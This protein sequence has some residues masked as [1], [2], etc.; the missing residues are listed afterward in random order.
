MNKKIAKK[1]ILQNF[2]PKNTKKNS[3]KVSLGS[4]SY[5]WEEVYEALDSMLKMRTTM[6]EKVG[7]FEKMFAKYIGVKYALMVNSG[8]SANLLAL[9]I[10]SNPLLKNRRIK[11]NDEI[12]TPA[13]TWST[14]VFPIVNIH[15][16]PV[17]L[18]VDPN[19]YNIDTKMIEK[20]ITKKTKAILP[21]HLLGNPCKMNEIKKIAKKYDLY[22]IEDCCEALG[23]KIKNKKVGSFGDLSTFSFFISHHITTM[24]GGM[25]L[26]NNEKF[27][28]LGKSLRTHGWSRDLKDKK[29]LIQ[30]NPNINSEFLFSNLGYNLRPT[31]IQGGFGIHQL[32]KLERFLK[33]RKLNADIW[34]KNLEK[35]EEFIELTKTETGHTHANMLF[36]IRIK[37]NKYFT[38]N[39]FVD[40]L[41]KNSIDTRPVMAGNFVLQP[42]AKMMKYKSIGK[43]K[44]STE[45]M[46]SSFL[47]GNHQDI[48]HN[49]REYV[50][51]IITKFIKSKISR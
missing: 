51:E 37:K 8:S 19:T 45:I 6:G 36:P 50:L 31:E 42:V 23:A 12:I 4:P 35:F 22:V 28:E 21:V 11:E 29:Q 25:L 20:A 5:G 10:L 7:T 46:K 49:A 48:D 2:L 32:K 44:N 15:A 38:K 39:E 3:R 26:T 33:I 14:T 9:S 18:D 34:R 40:Y 43:L 27:Y 30:K 1:F 47:L 24:E 41:E 17:F 13:L 16:K